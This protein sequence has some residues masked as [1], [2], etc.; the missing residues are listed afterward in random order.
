[1]ARVRV[2]CVLVAVAA[3]CIVL[4]RIGLDRLQD[5]FQSMRVGWFLAAVM[6]YG[7]LFLPAALRWH[8]ALDLTGNAVSV[9]TS[10]RLSIIGHFLYTILFGAAGGDTAK[11]ALY[12][13]WH[14][15]P[16]AEILAASSVDRLLGFGGLALLGGSAFIVGALNRGFEGFESLS[17]RSPWWWVAGVVIVAIIAGVLLRFGAAPFV[18]Q[19]LRA[20]VES[21]RKLLLTPGRFAGGIL[22]GLGVQLALSGVLAL[23]LQAVSHEPVPW[24]RMAWTFPVI[25]VIS[26][27]PISVAGLGVRESAAFVLFGLCQVAE[28]DA[29]AAALLTA[30]ASLVWMVI[31][32]FLL[33]LEAAR[34]QQPQGAG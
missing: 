19:F 34:R 22:C 5:A 3:L 12:A 21:G 26:A 8:I 16:L 27:L 4:R 20:L 7:L 33:W 11:S 31:G 29:V 23:N 18:Q 1:M 17:L 30:T 6:L 14:Q 10:V 2:A 25:T 15:R 24:L 13:R 32:G 9:G 28:E